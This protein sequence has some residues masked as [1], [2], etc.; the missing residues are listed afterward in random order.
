MPDRSVKIDRLVVRMRG[1]DE[2]QAR[3]AVAGLGEAVLRRLDASGVPGTLPPGVR[4]VERIDAGAVQLS[5]RD[6]IAT[7]VADAVAAQLRSRTGDR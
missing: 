1:V 3:E 6:G 2:A 7:Q 4:H 5:G